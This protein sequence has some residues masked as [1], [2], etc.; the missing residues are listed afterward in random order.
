MKNKIF[1]RRNLPHI[2]PNAERFFVTW[3][4]KDA[5]PIRKRATLMNNYK[6]IK[7]KI[8]EKNQLDIQSR[9][10]FKKY[11]DVLDREQSG[12]HYL[13]NKKLAK[14]VAGALHFWDN[15]RISLIAYCIMSNHVHLVL[16]MFEVDENGKELYLR[17]VLESIKKFSAREC[18]KIIGKTGEA[19]WH[20]ESYD[21]HIRDDAELYRIIEY[22]LKN[23]VKAGL[24]S[25]WKEWKFSYVADEFEP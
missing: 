24:C 12:S 14:V 8:K 1:Y 11:D 23:P 17:D 2:Q 19:F 5:I 7:Q 25:Y 18:N 3:T 22:T 6:L 21:R 15:K 16:Q 4:L 20:S 13:K 9:I 10:F